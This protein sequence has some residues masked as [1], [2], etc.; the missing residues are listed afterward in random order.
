[1]ILN[2]AYL[3]DDDRADAFAAAADELRAR[4]SGVRIELTGPWPAYSFT[5]LDPT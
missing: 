2:V 4:L 1:M 5:E 3:I